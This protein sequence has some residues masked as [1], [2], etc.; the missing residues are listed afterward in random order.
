MKKI[1]A[2]FDVD[3]T[4][5]KMKSM[6]EFYDF[7]CSEQGLF[8]ERE[9]Y[10]SRFQKGLSD[11]KSREFLNK[12]YYQQFK[13]VLYSDVINLGEEW[14]KVCLSEKAFIKE[15]TN[16]LRVHQREGHIPVFISGSMRPILEPIARYLDV[17]NIL[18]APVIIDPDGLMTGELGQLQTIGNGKRDALLL[19]CRKEDIDPQNCFAYG[20]DITDVP[21]LE[22]IGNPVCVGSNEKLLNYS[23]IKG[24]SNI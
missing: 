14:F 7:W 11:G 8:E 2:F 21:M 23:R 16:A 20:D 17:K 10:M 18:C 5:I 6:F 22:A 24:W 12:E 4:L 1:A 13:N 3:E 19:F 9:E 15:A